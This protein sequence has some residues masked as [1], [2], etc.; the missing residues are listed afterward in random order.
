M[1][2]PLVALRLLHALFPLDSLPLFQHR[3]QLVDP[4]LELLGVLLLLEQG[5]S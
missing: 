4:Q 5:A 3:L 2:E 1:D